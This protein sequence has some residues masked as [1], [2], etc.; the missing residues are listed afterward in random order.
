MRM[1]LSLSPIL[2]GILRFDNNP[3]FVYDRFKDYQTWSSGD[4]GKTK[5]LHPQNSQRERSPECSGA[6]STFQSIPNDRPPGPFRIGREGLPHQEIRRSGE[7]R[8]CGQ[9]FQL[10]QQA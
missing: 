10:Q 3:M 9:S 6:F 8:R 2:S 5:V 1:K 7:I 4:S